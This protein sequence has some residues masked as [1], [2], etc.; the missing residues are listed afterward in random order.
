MVREGMAGQ[1]R[2][3]PVTPNVAATRGGRPGGWGEKN[4]HWDWEDA[5]KVWIFGWVAVAAK[6]DLHGG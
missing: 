3:K 5:T 1:G 4:H 2:A 6:V